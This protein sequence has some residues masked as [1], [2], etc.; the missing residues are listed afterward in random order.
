MA[1][2]P[3]ADFIAYFFLFGQPSTAPFAKIEAHLEMA[4]KPSHMPAYALQPDQSEGSAP[5]AESPPSGGL[6]VAFTLF[7]RPTLHSDGS[8]DLP[9]LARI[10][11]RAFLCLRDG[12]W[13]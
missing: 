4:L 7:S 1:N 3:K 9:T 13:P 8:S 12:G 2:I 6:F 11:V 5:V 10:A